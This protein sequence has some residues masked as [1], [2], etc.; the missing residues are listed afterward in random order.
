MTMHAVVLGCA[1]HVRRV[2]LVPNLFTHLPFRDGIASE[3]ARKDHQ[4]AIEQSPLLEVENQLRERGVDLL[5][6]RS[7]PAR[8]HARACPSTGM[9]CIRSSP[10]RS[11]RRLRRDDAPT[12]T[13]DQ[14]GRCCT[15][16]THAVARATDRRLSLTE[17]SAGDRRIRATGS[18]I[19]AGSRPRTGRRAP[20]PTVSRR[21]DDGS[22][23]VCRQVRLEAE[24]QRPRPAGS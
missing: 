12:G 2:R 9:G 11:E 20:S 17:R 18:A 14:I 7:S 3:F 5:F 1:H 15:C 8:D 22:E 19:R 6:H 4:R 24:P 21:A 23:S 13:P 16:R 10:P